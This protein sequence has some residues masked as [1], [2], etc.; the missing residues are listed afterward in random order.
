MFGDMLDIKTTFIE[1]SNAHMERFDPFS[2]NYTSIN[3][4]IKFD[5]KIKKFKGTN[6]FIK[7]EAN[8]II[9]AWRSLTLRDH[10]LV[11]DDAFN[12]LFAEQN[13]RYEIGAMEGL[14]DN[15][16]WEEYR[17][18]LNTITKWVHSEKKYVS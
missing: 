2:Q 6:Y 8:T 3:V 14:V 1:E 4:N 15:E 11:I 10:I 13:L 7:E 17:N 5:G 12:V 18:N 16:T 9:K